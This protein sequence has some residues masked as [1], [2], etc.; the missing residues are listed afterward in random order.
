MLLPLSRVQKASIL[1]FDQYNF[2]QT[3]NLP[4]AHLAPLISLLTTLFTLSPS[5]PT[6]S[7]EIALP[8]IPKFAQMLV[9]ILTRAVTDNN[10]EVV[11]IVL[12]HIPSL[13]K[14]SPTPSRPL[15]P[16]LLPVLHRLLIISPSPSIS[17]SAAALLS[18]L[19]ILPGKTSA[20][21]QFGTDLRIATNE[22][23]QC[24]GHV[25]NDGWMRRDGEIKEMVGLGKGISRGIVG[26][27]GGDGGN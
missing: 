27:L 21:T 17:T 2:V 14:L 26:N 20:T 15:L 16:I 1:Q 25:W 6:F 8:S 11:E 3:P 10:W 19:H 22:G 12:P 24:L 18:T 13:I 9:G 5:Y 4:Q 23:M 7:R